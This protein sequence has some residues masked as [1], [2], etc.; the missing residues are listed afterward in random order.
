MGLLR[1]HTLLQDLIDRA[2][3]A[4]ATQ[5]RVHR[6]LNAVVSVASDLSLP[7][8]LYRIVESG[9]DL[10]GA[11]YG[12]IGVI[13]IDRQLV[14][15]IHVGIDDELR[16]R[17][18][19]L[20]TGKG[21][22]GQLIA[23]PKP[24]RLKNLH[25][26]PASSGFPRNHPPMRSFLGVPVHVRGEVFG[27]LYLT[28]KLDGG[29]FTEEDVDV[30]VALA[31]AAGIAIENA[32]LYAQSSQRER[33]LRA[34]H[35]VTTAL[36]GGVADEDGL[37]QIAERAMEVAGAV[38]S[39]VVMPD[40]IGDGL[41]HEMIAGELTHDLAQLRLPIADSIAG[42]VFTSGVSRVLD[43]FG[44]ALQSR[45][46][47]AMLESVPMSAKELGPAMLVPLGAGQHLLGVLVL[48]RA[49]GEARFEEP[50][51]QMAQA[52]ARQAALSIEFARSQDDRH[53]LAVYADRDRIARDLHDQVIQ[54]LF[55]IGMGLQGL[56]RVMRPY[57][58]DRMT[59]FVSDLDATIQEIRRTIFSLQEPPDGP[60][61]V[62]G[63]V[64][65]LISEMTGALGFEPT[66]R[67]SGPLDSVVPDEMQQDLLATL[68]E[69]LSN[70]VKHAHACSVTVTV[71]VD[72]SATEL[73]LRVSDDGPGM[74]EQPLR[75]SGLLNI[76]DRAHRWGGRC[77][78]ESASGNGTTVAWVV[79]I[80]GVG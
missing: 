52:F 64:Q 35:Q 26:H 8:V 20:P 74:P 51:V 59:G 17:I 63:G 7:D 11:R 45:L 15:F 54:R 29:E 10:V 78:M 75:R 16:E 69:T 77:D 31:A 28:E 68:R 24:L 6:L 46:S 72:R 37:R 12:A 66:V 73:A 80:E 38:H 19:D 4:V 44:Q 58:A 48:A 76:A 36:L 62:R 55:A 60:V 33:W 25:A 21:I 3:A 61:R 14:E 65:R 1:G 49:R 42:D 70:I 27:N 40:D 71:T 30:V 32:R 41:L 79:P 22:L 67:L 23:D 18:G 34:S 39:A 5:E 50:E 57:L 9:C 43:D 53:R 13:G 2:T 47:S 56:S